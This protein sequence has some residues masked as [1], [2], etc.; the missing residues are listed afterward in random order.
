[1]SWTFLPSIA[2]LGRSRFVEIRMLTWLGMAVL[3]DVTELSVMCL[4]QF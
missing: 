4:E 3:E 2:F 1:M